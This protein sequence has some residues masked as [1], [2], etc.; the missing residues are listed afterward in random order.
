MHIPVLLHE[1]VDGLALVPGDVFVDATVNGAGHSAFVAETHGADV[2]IIGIDQDERALVNAEK[3]LKLLSAKFRL[4]HGNFRHIDLLLAKLG[5][6]HVHKILFDLGFS[7]TQL[8]DG[9]GLSFMKDEPLLMTLTGKKDG[10]TAE[11]ILNSWDEEN[12][13]QIVSSY[14]EERFAKRIAK[15]IVEARAKTAIK[16]TA[17]LVRIIKEATP[18]AYQRGK[19]HFA[20][21]TFQALRIVVNDEI[22]S[23]KEGLQNSWKVLAPSGRIAVI[24]FHSIEDRIVKRFGRGKK[25]CG[26]A[27]ILTKKP[28]TPGE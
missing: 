26:E 2:E 7:S 27:V 25:A 6:Q 3:R 13:A 21:R 8:E 15:K 16:S 5:K 17:D 10:L 24:S 4:V 14:G 18:A 23:L 1:S 9:R 11:E 28:I 20:T 22:A 19:I 12:I